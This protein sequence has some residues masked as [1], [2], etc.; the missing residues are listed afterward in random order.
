[1]AINKSNTPLWMKATLILLAIVFVF[2]FISI[3]ASPFMGTDTTTPPA[4]GTGDTIAQQ[5]Q[6]TVAALTA[7][8]QSDPESYTALVNLGNTYFDWAAQLQQASQ[9]DSATIGADLPI[10]VAAKDAYGRAVALKSDEPPVL[11]D[12]AITV[13]YTG[14]TDKAIVQVEKVIK[15]NPEFPPSYFNLG[16]FLTALGDNAKAVAAYQKYLELDP[17][18]EQGNAD[19]AKQEL[20][21]LG[22]QVG[23]STAPATSAP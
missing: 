6:P 14:E 20:E 2:G 23:T 4:A 22:A 9:T 3:G 5:F 18:G 11:V 17:K 12:Y 19:F 16:V 10:W 8:I 13:F 1:M 21:R 7:A 15:K